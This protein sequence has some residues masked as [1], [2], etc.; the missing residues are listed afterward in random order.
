MTE[1]ERKARRR[2]ME[3]ARK[4]ELRQPGYY[5]HWREKNQERL[6]LQPPPMTSEARKEHDREYQRNW[7]RRF[8][9]QN[10]ERAREYATRWRAENPDKVKEMALRSRETHRGEARERSRQ[11]RVVNRERGL[12]STRRWILEHPEYLREYRRNR[13]S[14][15]QAAIEYVRDHGLLGD[16]SGLT[17]NTVRQVALEYVRQAGLLLPPE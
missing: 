11:W 6:H 15:L 10:P 1:E 14:Q 5:A 13:Y 9:E 12:E 16:I 4:R 17:R 2:E 8:R 7:K 3:T